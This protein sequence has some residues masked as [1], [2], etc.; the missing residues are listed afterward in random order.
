MLPV[1]AVKRAPEEITV[2]P[3]GNWWEC[4]RS[5]VRG[6]VAMS[7]RV[8]RQLQFELEQEF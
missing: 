3:H 5:A 1:S 7:E 8:A 2:D 4:E 6:V